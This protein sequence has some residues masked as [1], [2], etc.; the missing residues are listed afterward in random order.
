MPEADVSGSVN[1][2]AIDY[3]NP[4]P[5][6]LKIDWREHLRRVE[7]P[8]AEVNYV[9]I[10]EGEPILFVHGIWPAPGRT[11][12]RTSPT[13]AAPTARSRSTCPAS[14][15]ARCPPGRSTCPPTGA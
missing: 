13:S 2:P 11:G 14:A 4:D 6:W 10:G 9:E 8:G 3:G 7:L 1:F 15:T 12:S 5:E